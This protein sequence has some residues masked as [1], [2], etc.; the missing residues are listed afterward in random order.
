MEGE[1][2]VA[3]RPRAYTRNANINRLR[4]HMLA[5]LGYTRAR[6]TCPQEVIAPWGSVPAD[7]IDDAIRATQGSHQLV[8]D[9]ELMG[10]VITSVL[11]AVVAKEVVQLV[12]SVRQVGAPDPVHDIDVLACM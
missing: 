3:Q 7:D 12:E 6:A 5:V 10:I 2:S 1:S 11:S 9:V 8:Q 4:Q